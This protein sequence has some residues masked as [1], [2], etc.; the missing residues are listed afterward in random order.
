MTMHTSRNYNAEALSR[1]EKKY[2]YNFD[3]IVRQYM[4]RR[5]APFFGNGPALELGCHEGQST[6]LLAEHFDNLTVIEAS[7]EAIGIARQSVGPSVRF[8]NSTFENAQ[9]EARFDSIFL[10]NTLEHVDEPNAILTRIRQW[11]RPGG[12]FFVLVPNADAP[13]RQIAVQMGLIRTNNAVT[14][15]EWAHGHRRTYSFDTLEADLREAGFSIEQRG[16]LMFKALA[17]FQFD[18]AL[19]AGIIDEQYLEG[20]YQLGMIY[21]AMTASIYMICTA[22]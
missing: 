2:S 12:K 15:G 4:M 11:L 1:P 13:S 3:E 8:I 17:N 19:E 20:I 14:P 21:P 5:F 10:I 16:G 7:S 22:S 6:L 9:L 18:K